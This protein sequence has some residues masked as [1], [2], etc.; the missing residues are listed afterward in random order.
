M[1]QA[2]DIRPHMEVLG[3]DGAHVGTV[4]HVEGT[5]IK[6][7][8]RDSADDEHHH[9]ALDQV[10]RV[11]AHVHLA[12]PAATALAGGIGAAVASA[13]GDP[14]G[15]DPHDPLPPTRNRAV[16][17]ARPRGN[18]YLPWVVGIVGL[19][20]LL[21]LFKSCVSSK[22]EETVAR[23]PSAVTAP[24]GVTQQPATDVPLP[25]GQQVQVA[26]NTLAFELERY[27]A[28]A[29]AA[30]RGF[31]FDR[32]NFDTASATI[33]AEDG[34]TLDTVARI[35]SAYPNARVAITGYADARGSDPANATLGQA[36][37]QA[38]VAALGQRGV[39][40]TRLEARSG[41]EGNPADTNA[42]APG[43]AEN[44]RTEL[45]VVAK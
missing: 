29:D 34:A 23:D 24:A 10:A 38:V 32:L 42:T 21:L 33:R 6:L 19:V 13:T 44:R 2:S 45:E 17:G 41:G 9:V 12:I 43:Q 3:S 14:V 27:L 11:D 1:A 39:A 5:R 7:T 36:R 22:E 37:A 15:D 35:L 26:P 40:R 8:R 4:D 16:E 31:T 25:G 18:Y 30:P 28:S 20:L